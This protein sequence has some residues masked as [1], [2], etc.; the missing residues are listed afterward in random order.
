MPSC[1][2][3]GKIYLAENLTEEQRIDLSF[4]LAQKAAE[5]QIGLNLNINLTKEGLARYPAKDYASEGY[6]PY[7]IVDD[8][9]SDDCSRLFLG[10]AYHPDGMRVAS[11][12]FSEVKRVQTF[13]I[14]AIQHEW[15]SHM[16][17]DF[18]D[19]HG[20]P[21]RETYACEIKA[22]QLCQ[23]ILEAPNELNRFEIP[24]LRLKI[25]K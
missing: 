5:A 24:A 17:I 12:D 8:P 22:D 9:L 3:T 7:E 2:V 1:I 21:V 18:E 10:I 6:I 13:L 25:T 14:H 4:F 15:I 19:V 16:T 20:W 11:L 23:A